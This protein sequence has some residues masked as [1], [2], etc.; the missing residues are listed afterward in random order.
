[1][2]G[3]VP[4]HWK[5]YRVR[6]I[7]DVVN[8]YPFD[9]AFFGADGEHP[10]VRIRDLNNRETTTKYSGSF[11]E[12]AAVTPADILVGMDGDFNV[13]RW[14]GN[15]KALLNQRMCAV[16]TDDDLLSGFLE[17]FLPLP[18]KAIND[19]TYSTTVKHLSSNQ[20][21]KVLIALPQDRMELK[22]LV[23]YLIAEVSKIEELVA[24]QA[25]LQRL[26]SEKRFATIFHAVTRGLD[27]STE[28]KD[29]G[30]EWLSEVP[31]HWSVKQIRHI[32]HILRGKFTHRPRNDP[33]Y[34]DGEHPFIQTGDITAASR[35][36]T[37]Y[38]QTLNN[39]GAAVSRQ[40]PKGTLVMAI[41]AN[42]GD[43]A[44]LDFPAYFP[45]SV[46][47]LVPSAGVSVEFLFYLMIAMKSPMLQ[48]ATVSTQLNLNVDQIASLTAAVPPQSE[49]LCIARFLNS[50][51]SRIDAL[52]AESSR[53][54]QL[55][56]ERRNALVAE[57]ATGKIN[58]A[59][60]EVMHREMA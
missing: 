16:R 42:I 22:V 40:F 58:V 15:G 48:T 38:K 50:E 10:L 53:A 43:V 27:P 54:M 24:E 32:A 31:R 57:V 51:L 28:F 5:I 8:G 33:A 41:A 59:C 44:I 21:E 29:S 7:A 45:D 20:V 23:E 34:Y 1:M 26:L 39:R 4:A 3:S 56:Q 55:L 49:Q 47:G 30:I 2:L 9:A 25:T 37:A 46:V 11:V 35:N 36:I 60:G 13:G 18:L 52:V 6:D 14:R 19:V 12:A 17:L